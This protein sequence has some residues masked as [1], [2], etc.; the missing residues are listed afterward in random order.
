[1]GRES[2]REDSGCDN[3][4]KATQGICVM[5]VEYCLDYVTVNILCYEFEDVTIG[6]K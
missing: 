3:C 4:Q 5:M 6:G 2:V 1:V